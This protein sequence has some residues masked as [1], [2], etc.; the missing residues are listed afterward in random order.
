MKTL[1]IRTL[2]QEYGAFLTIKELGAEFKFSAKA[3]AVYKKNGVLPL[4]TL[5]KRKRRNIFKA[6]DIYDFLR[7]YITVVRYD[8][9]NIEQYNFKVKQQLE[10][11]RVRYKRMLISIKE[12]S[13]LLGISTVTINTRMREKV[14][15]PSYIKFGGITSTLR[16]SIVDVAKYLV[17]TNKEQQPKKVDYTKSIDTVSFRINDYKMDA[18]I[19][20]YKSNGYNTYVKSLEHLKVLICIDSASQNHM[21]K[22][23]YHPIS[24]ATYIE[25]YGIKA[26]TAKDTEMQYVLKLFHEYI[27]SNKLEDITT[28]SKLD[29]AYDFKV[30]CS[31]IE[32]QDIKLHHPSKN[33]NDDA[34]Y[35]NHSFYTKHI[36]YYK[37]SYKNLNTLEHKFS[38][39]IPTYASLFEGVE[40]RFQH[41]KS[42][43]TYFDILDEY[44]EENWFSTLTQNDKVPSKKEFTKRLERYLDNAFYSRGDFIYITRKFY[45]DNS[46]IFRSLQDNENMYFHIKN[47]SSCILYNKANKSKLYRDLSRVEFKIK[48]EEKDRISYNDYI[49]SNY[50]DK[51]QTKLSK[52]MVFVDGDWCKL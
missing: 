37:T 17:S 22:I 21:F 19:E 4:Y 28:I 41:Y 50:H 15:I 5:Q 35:Q 33:I 25:F 31:Q 38:V 30:K 3:M 42:N 1:H 51:V 48:F 2:K 23:F 47:D 49:T 52:Y 46:T 27:N 34:Y 43:S 20:Y 6:E 8:N 26:W 29:V 11:L 13:Q 18:I 16:F 32:L 40:K 24:R 7:E 10:V 9:S 36:D 12:L 39:M 44:H 45:D 14:N